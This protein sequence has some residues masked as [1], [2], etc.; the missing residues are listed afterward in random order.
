MK[1][2]QTKKTPSAKKSP[3]ASLM[4]SP[5]VGKVSSAMAKTTAASKAKPKTAIKK[6]VKAGAKAS[7]KTLSK[8]ATK[9]GNKTAAKAGKKTAAKT[10]TKGSTKSASKTTPKKVAKTSSRAAAKTTKS[11]AKSGAK[12]TTKSLAG[13]RAKTGTVSKAKTVAKSKAKNS[14]KTTAKKGAAAKDKAK[15]VTK[16]GGKT[17]NAASGANARAAAGAVKAVSDANAL[18]PYDTIKLLSDNYRWHEIL[19]PLVDESRSISTLRADLADVPVLTDDGKVTNVYHKLESENFLHRQDRM[20]VWRCLALVREAYLQLESSADEGVK[21]YQWNM[22]WKHTRAEVDQVYEASKILGLTSDETRDA[23]LASIF[24]DSIKN[25]SNF[26]IHNVH[27]SQAAALALSYFWNTESDEHMH[28]VQR[29]VLAI[30]QHQ[31]APPEFMARTVVVLLGRKFRL[32]SFDQIVRSGM[33]HSPDETKQK[34]IV[35][36]I[37][38]KIGHPFEEKNLTADLG[39]INFTDEERDMLKQIGIFDWW[40][41]HPKVASSKIAHALITGDHSIN[42]NNPDGFA[43]IALIR[44]PATEAV[45]EDATIYDSLESAMASFADSF[46]ILLPE[47]RPLALRGIRRTHVAVTRVMRMMTELFSGVVEGPRESAINITGQALVAQALERAKQKNPGLFDAAAIYTSEAGQKYLDRSLERVGSLL[48]EW[49]SSNGAIPFS[50][51]SSSHS[52]PGPGLL[53]FWN[54]ALKYPRRN[55]QGQIDIHSLTPY[56]QKQFAFAQRIR[57]IA[58]E[59]LRAEQWFFS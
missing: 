26:I 11:T 19:P 47:V 54:S 6:P 7:A 55:E 13:S 37:Y 44:G 18:S 42:Y 4:E 20:V 43:K 51:R 48:E 17:K 45:F 59:L 9:A 50:I 24:S 5:R 56:E 36:S 39:R 30:K 25:R 40:V 29:I 22:N 46:N 41:P 53:P 15:A 32:G 12:A 23:I 14:P 33:S 8:T 10:T 1:A 34:Y 52:E 21:G 57:E 49:K 3:K 35:R 31:I 28:S 2:N 58:V 16:S 38:D 27:G